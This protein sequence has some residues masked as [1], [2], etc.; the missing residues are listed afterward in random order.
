MFWITR[1][2]RGSEVIALLALLLTTPLSAE[3][4]IERGEY[5]VRAANCVSCH[6]M[7]GGDV[8]AG[9][10]A[11]PTD[12]GTIYSTNITPDRKTGIGGWT[13]AQFTAALRQ[14]VRP[15]G[16]HLYPAF[17]YTSFTKLN[18]ADVQALYAYFMN[19]RPVPTPATPNDMRFPFRHRSLLGA[20][21]ML[22]FEEGRYIADPS[23]SEQWNR[24]A[25]LVEGAA[26]CG[27]CH[28]PRNLLGAEKTSL[29][30]AGGVLQ[31][32]VDDR[33]VERAAPNLTPSPHGLG[34]WS[35]SDITGY[36]KNG[37]SSR[38]R[39]MGT[40]NEVVL[41]ST[42]HLTEADNRAMAVYLKSLPARVEP[43]S[44]PGDALMQFGSRQYDIH[45]GTCHLPTG[46]GSE[47][48]GPPLAGSALAQAPSP[49]SLIDLVINGPRLPP[50]A[51]SDAW[52]A[53]PWQSMTPFS[54]KLSDEEAAALL[55]FV[56]N[57]WGNAASVVQPDDIDALR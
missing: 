18:D 44:K 47:D 31:E 35:E 11:F 27:A 30:Y 9:G 43:A 17:P 13:L 4:A 2:N 24:G 22:F 29:A 55:T 7:P 16:E 37:V 56:R 21:K 50:E 54:Q 36:L 8:F 53:R 48:T 23:R 1:S 26:H 28:T 45:C 20:W 41:N 10:V 52:R 25:Y 49:S 38:M 34:A 6:T 39:L 42:R 40:M 57:S 51:P 46:L 5:L 3:D 32:I 15:D 19:L 33:A 14:G 12:F